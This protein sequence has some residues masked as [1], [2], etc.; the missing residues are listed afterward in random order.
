MV[1]NGLTLELW[2]LAFCRRGGF[3][4]LKAKY[5]CVTIWKTFHFFSWSTFVI[6]NIYS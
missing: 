1:S 3:Y 2:Q 6:F 4:P 5:S